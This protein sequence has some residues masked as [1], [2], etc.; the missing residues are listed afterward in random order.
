MDFRCRWHGIQ[1]RLRCANILGGHMLQYRCVFHHC[2]FRLILKIVA[3][4]EGVETREQADFLTEC[5]CSQLQGYFYGRPMPLAE[6]TALIWRA[7]SGIDS[8][9]MRTTSVAA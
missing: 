7:T 1:N 4:A 5:G 8:E 3:L 2:L 6:A 9:M